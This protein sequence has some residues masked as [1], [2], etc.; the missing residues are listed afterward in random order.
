M[1]QDIITYLNETNHFNRIRNSKA[2]SYCCNSICRL[3]MYSFYRCR[4]IYLH[5]GI[6]LSVAN[7]V[8]I[9]CVGQ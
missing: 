3:Q 6:Q 8:L 9:R 7:P 2:L 1:L 5:V 4:N